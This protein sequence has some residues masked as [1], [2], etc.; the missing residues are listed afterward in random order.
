MQ[1]K[2]VN[3]KMRKL[4]GDVLTPINI[5]LRLEGTKKFL[6]ES[7]L[8]HS[9]QGRYS[10]IGVNPV[11]EIVGNGNT[12]SVISFTDVKEQIGL[13]LDIIQNTLPKLD[14]ELPFPFYGGAVGYVGYDAIRQYVDI[15]EE[16]KDEI[17]M[18]DIHFMVY[19]DAIVYDHLAQSIYVLA[20]DLNGERTEE[21]LEQRINKL[22]AQISRKEQDESLTDCKIEFTPQ[23]E[24]EEFIRKVEVAQEFI[25]KGEIEQVVLSQRMIGKV[26]ADPFHFYRVLRNSNPSPYMFYVDFD[27]YVVL[28]ASP[29]SFIK[30]SG[31][32]VSTNPI[33]G[34][35]RRGETQ[36]EDLA[37][38]AELLA[39]EKELS[40]HRMLV[41][42][43]SD[44]LSKI[45]VE[46][47][48]KINSHMKI[49]R[50][51][52]VMHIVS[53]MEGTLADGKTGIDALISCIPAGTV[54]GA[55]KPRAMQIINDLEEVKRGVYAGAIGY[56]NANGDVDFAIAIR[57]LVIKDQH[58][59]LQAG[60]G[61]VAESIPKN[62]YKETI[63]KA[64]ALLSPKPY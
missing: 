46:D 23:L 57:S 5:F 43:S 15:G 28:G 56:I 10:F 6:L 24:K 25:K 35:R 1:T 14:L 44:D 50:Y 60:A 27:E 32:I 2:Q 20:I 38:E 16:L 3:F 11:M 59:Y 42:L 34:T 36:D 39:D 26:E 52:H 64:R 22:E 4:N 13:P 54:S 21:E 19:E 53:E 63:N 58:A 12:A 33:A 17:N 8:K 41:D 45:C 40:E 31:R 47:T 51:R 37:L 9:E 61:I 48:I 62:E 49:E 7:S 18:P 55:P 29:E 30:T